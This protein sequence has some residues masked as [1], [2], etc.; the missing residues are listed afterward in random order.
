MTVL[1][2]TPNPAKIL[3]DWLAQSP[4]AV[5]YPDLTYAL[6]LDGQW[7]PKTSRP[8]LVVF[9]DGGPLRWPVETKT[10]LRVTIWSDDLILGREAA[11]FAMGLCLTHR[12]PGLAKVLPGLSV[13]DARDT[14]NG[15]IM[16]S[17]TVRAR[18][19]TTMAAE[20]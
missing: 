5:R 1:V 12:I 8:A 4:L 10:T 11:A 17:Y 6:H 20:A 3:K 7:A 15:G 2:A 14:N 9:D 19:R 18:V 13:T 16:A